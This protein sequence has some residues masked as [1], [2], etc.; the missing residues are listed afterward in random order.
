MTPLDYSDQKYSVYIEVF[1]SSKGEVKE[2][3]DN[4]IGKENF[5]LEKDY[6]FVYR[7]TVQSIPE[8]IRELAVRNY[9]IYGII[10]DYIFQRE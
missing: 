9:A 6:G 3:I 8:V 4:Y 1:P 10:P 7:M 5:I 2:I